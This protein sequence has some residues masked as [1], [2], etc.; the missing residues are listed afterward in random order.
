MLAVEDQAIR[1]RRDK[2]SVPKVIGLKKVFLPQDPNKAS[3]MSISFFEEMK[4]RC[5]LRGSRNRQEDSGNGQEKMWT[6][7]FGVEENTTVLT[8]PN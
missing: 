6:K 8:Y 2:D 4:R 7:S 5:S 3:G 1:R